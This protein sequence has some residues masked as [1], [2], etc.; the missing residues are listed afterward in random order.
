MEKSGDTNVK[1]LNKALERIKKN[2]HAEKYVIKSLCENTDFDFEK[3]FKFLTDN[4]II[5]NNGGDNKLSDKYL[6][7]FLFNE[8]N[9]KVFNLPPNYFIKTE[10]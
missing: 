6:T 5:I 2:N 7:T 9:I 10:L 8:E 4:K 3:L 1:I